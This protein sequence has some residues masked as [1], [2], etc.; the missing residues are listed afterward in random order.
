MLF[1]SIPSG[2]QSSSVAKKETSKFDFCFF[3]F[4]LINCIYIL[5]DIIRAKFEK[6]FGSKT[7]TDK[8]T[9]DELTQSICRITTFYQKL[10]QTLTELR[11]QIL[12]G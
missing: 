6:L 7:T 2:N 1:E 12:C 3:L 9:T 10:I 4:Y 11:L 8:L 5:K